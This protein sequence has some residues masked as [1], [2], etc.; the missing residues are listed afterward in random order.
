MEQQTQEKFDVWAVVEIM[1]HQRIAGR[2]SEQSIAGTN[3]LRV[4]V[5][6]VEFD[7][8]AWDG[9]GV[10]KIDGFTTYI[11]G[12]SIYR[13]TP[14]TEAVARKA[15]EQF[16]VRPVQCVDLSPARALPAP[17]GDDEADDSFDGDPAEELRY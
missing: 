12:S 9:G 4:D 17:V 1:G 7:R 14:C 5:P 13:M 8:P 11:G 15:V 2:C 3:L 10:E 16:R 6:S